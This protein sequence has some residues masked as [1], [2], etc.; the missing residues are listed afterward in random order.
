MSV[1]GIAGNRNEEVAT[2]EEVVNAMEAIRE[3]ASRAATNTFS[4]FFMIGTLLVLYDEVL[5]LIYMAYFTTR[6]LLGRSHLMQFSNVFYFFSS[7]FS[8]RCIS[9]ERGPTR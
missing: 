6:Q 3:T 2:K 8:G 9:D 1:R 7:F 4:I 5:Y